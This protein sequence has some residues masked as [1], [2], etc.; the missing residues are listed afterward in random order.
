MDT[1]ATTLH[2]LCQKRLDLLRSAL[3]A[4][5]AAPG[6]NVQ[7]TGFALSY[8][9]TAGRLLGYIEEDFNRAGKEGADGRD[10]E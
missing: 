9:S 5:Q 8:L 10:S 6:V 3:E 7:Y 2:T 1:T 4:L